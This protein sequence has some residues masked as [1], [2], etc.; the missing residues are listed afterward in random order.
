MEDL[1]L[2]KMRSSIIEGMC[3]ELE[4]NLKNIDI[5][6]EPVK[7]GFVTP[8]FV[9]TNVT[10]EFRS[11]TFSKY[12]Y[13]S[14]FKIMYYP[15]SEE[16]NLECLH[17]SEFL[18]ENLNIIFANFDKELIEGSNFVSEIKENILTFRVDYNAIVRKSQL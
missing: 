13:L 2:V 16:P 3:K 10:D 7:Q 18:H 9:V 6:T 5:H 15:S 1:K 14:T 12:V 8:C 11:L 17:M 4:C